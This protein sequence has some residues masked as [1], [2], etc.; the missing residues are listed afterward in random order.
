MI[1]YLKNA[2]IIPMSEEKKFWHENE[3]SDFTLSYT[4]KI[5]I[6]QFE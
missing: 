3:L 2:L 6:S 5:F 4:G 1:I